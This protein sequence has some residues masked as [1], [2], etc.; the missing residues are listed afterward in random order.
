MK[1]VRL[2][3]KAVKKVVK[4]RS[5]GARGKNMTAEEQRTIRTMYHDNGER[6]VDIA[7]HFG[8]DKSAIYRV[9]F[10]QFQGKGPGRPRVLSKEQV[11]R[12]VDKTKELTKKAAGKSDV[13]KAQVR[14]SA[15]CKASVK[16]I[17]RRFKEQKFTYHTY[18]EMILL[19]AEDK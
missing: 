14:R 12:L 11:A 16:T 7:Q 3:K 13:T 6:V 1:F 17:Q 19:S 15:R 2:S 10:H 9:L 8:R 5:R 18:K 4:K